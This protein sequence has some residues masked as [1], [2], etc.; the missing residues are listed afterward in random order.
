MS[1]YRTDKDL[2]NVGS[3]TSPRHLGQ[4]DRPYES[5]CWPRRLSITN[6]ISSASGYWIS[7][8]SRMQAA[9]SRA[10]RCSVTF[11]WR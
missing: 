6:R 4:L 11:T 2:T 5:G 7:A 3:R 9:K 8:R 1:V 10:V